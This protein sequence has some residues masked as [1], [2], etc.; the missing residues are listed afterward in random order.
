[1]PAVPEAGGYNYHGEDTVLPMRKTQDRRPSN[2][3]GVAAR[4]LE[5]TDRQKIPRAQ[6]SR[7]TDGQG[8]SRFNEV[9]SRR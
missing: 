9:L 4:L 5:S 7:P 2:G 8:L 6:M 1:V 3:I